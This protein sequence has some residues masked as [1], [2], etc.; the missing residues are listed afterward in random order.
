LT[1][2][3]HRRP[4]RDQELA[5]AARWLHEEPTRR[6]IVPGE[7]LQLCFD[8]VEPVDLGYAHRRRWYLVSRAAVLRKCADEGLADNAIK[9]E[10]PEQ[11]PG[12]ARG[13][14]E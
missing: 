12:F 10:I 8:K 9:Y 4:D 5:D 2:F 1:N 7:A 11:L 3:G 13:I 14:I 6:L